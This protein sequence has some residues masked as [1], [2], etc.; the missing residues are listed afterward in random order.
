MDAQKLLQLRKDVFLERCKIQ[1]FTE[2]IYHGSPKTGLQ[3]ILQAE[4]IIAPNHGE[5]GIPLFST[6]TD[7]RI[8]G[9][10][11]EGDKSWL[12][13]WVENLP[14]LCLDNF[15]Y[16]LTSCDGM[17]WDHINEHPEDEEL[18]ELLGY[19]KGA[20]ELEG[21]E[22]EELFPEGTL[23]IGLPGWEKPYE[24]QMK[25]S[26]IA[27][28]QEGCNYLWNKIEMITLDGKELNFAEGRKI[29]RNQ[30]GQQPPRLALGLQKCG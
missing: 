10:F 2:Y 19:Y 13:F 23:A 7:D 16:S 24:S 14:I 20:P 15:H 6:S 11:S 1:I 25:E 17:W 22:L 26:E 30:Q 9:I 28:T 5:L 29:L 3:E 12:T 27:F 8:P 18:A 4:E 21:V